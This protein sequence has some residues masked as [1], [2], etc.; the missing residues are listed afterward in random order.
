MV[1]VCSY[2]AR[3]PPVIGSRMVRGR[4]DGNGDA[5]WAVAISASRTAT[6]RHRRA[7]VGPV[8]AVLLERVEPLQSGWLSWRAARKVEF[9]PDRPPCHTLPNPPAA[10]Q[11][12]QQLQASSAGRLEVVDAV[13][14]PSGSAVV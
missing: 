2:R 13:P 10:R 6:R 1:G 4:A 9:E 14:Q 5:M 8:E 3:A 11:G 7:G 12:L